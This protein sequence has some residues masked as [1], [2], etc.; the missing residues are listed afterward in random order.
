MVS[1]QDGNSLDKSSSAINEEEVH[2]NN[3]VKNSLFDLATSSEV[4]EVFKDSFG[5]VKENMEK[6]RRK[7]STSTDKV[8]VS[9]AAMLLSLFEI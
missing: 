8:V 9:D 6:K 4:S 3:E 1:I 2:L 7:F 5:E